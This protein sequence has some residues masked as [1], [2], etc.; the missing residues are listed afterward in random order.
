[1]AL[2]R[3]YVPFLES[4]I[5]CIFL[6]SRSRNLDRSLG[7]QFRVFCRHSLNLVFEM[8]VTRWWM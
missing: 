5:R 2:A 1:M 6:L 4:L 8:R 7:L 3:L